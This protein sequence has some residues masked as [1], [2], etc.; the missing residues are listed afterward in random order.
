MDPEP[1]S[2]CDPVAGTSPQGEALRTEATDG[3]DVADAV[4]VIQATLAPSFL[5][6]GASIFLNFTQTRLFRVIDRL[7]ALEP[8]PSA[9][10]EVLQTRA[11]TLRNAIV[12]GVFTVALTVMTAIFVMGGVMFDRPGFTNAAP[13]VFALAMLALFGALCF[14]LYDTVL[15][16][17]TATR[18]SPAQVR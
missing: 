3:L 15:S 13:W 6:S 4:E 2:N 16:V 1:P 5:I 11:R 17:R 18:D 7:R 14:V 8:G 9:S 12:I 10:R